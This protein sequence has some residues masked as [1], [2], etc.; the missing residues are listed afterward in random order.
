MVWGALASVG[1]SMVIGFLCYSPFSLGKYWMRANYPGQTYS[2]VKEGFSPAIMP[3]VLCSSSILVAV[4]HYFV[5]PY[6]GVTSVPAALKVGLA[7]SVVNM[8]VNFPHLL[9]NRSSVVAYL[10][11]HSYNAAVVTASCLCLVYFS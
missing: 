7:L 8:L 4:L 6:L 2:Q 10:I 5:G 11:D 9:Y 3:L 1:M